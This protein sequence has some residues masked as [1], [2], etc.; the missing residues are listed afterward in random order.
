M[1]SAD[2]PKIRILLANDQDVVRL[3]LKIIFQSEPDLDLVAVAGSLDDTV[4][5]SLRHA[6]DITLLDCMLREGSCIERIPE[7]LNACPTS[8]ILV[9]TACPSPRRHLLALRSGACGVFVLH[10]P[11]EIFDQSDSQGS[12][13]QGMDSK[14]SNQINVKRT[15][16][17][18]TLS[19]KRRHHRSDR[20]NLNVERIS[21]GPVSINRLCVHTSPSGSLRIHAFL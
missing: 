4:N 19:K 13:R 3:G 9:L 5:L 1:E 18:R 11:I 14:Q 6:P 10:Q 17:R 16:Q 15:L 20:Q 7:L 21:D 2:R 8:K 12:G